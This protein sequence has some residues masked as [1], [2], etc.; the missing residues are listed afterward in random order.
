MFDDGAGPPAV[1]KSSRVLGVRVDFRHKRASVAFS[2]YHQPRILSFFEGSAQQLPDGHYF[3]GWGFKPYFS[4]F[5][6]GRQI[7][8]GRFVCDCFHN[9]AYRF[10]WN[11]TPVG[12][13][14]L[15][16]AG[17][18]RAITVFASWNG[19]TN[20]SYWRVLGGS[21]KAHLRPIKRA[22]ASGFETAIHVRGTPYI[23]VVALDSRGR[24]LSSESK[25]VRG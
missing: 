2:D 16:V 25:V 3:A 10:R 9:R 11:A 5:A 15:A 24:A 4:E 18:G 6:G 17:R 22:R 23:A 7:F 1:H 14:D 20:V 19:A 13:P 21:T 8:D 12:A